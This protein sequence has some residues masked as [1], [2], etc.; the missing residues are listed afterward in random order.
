MPPPRAV[1]T[2][3]AVDGG[4]IRVTVELEAGR[5]PIEGR[6]RVS[7]GGWHAF[8]GWLELTALLDGA[9]RAPAVGHDNRQPGTDERTP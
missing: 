2:V 3:T 4:T 9:E 5:T 1:S 7:D 6:L 8:A